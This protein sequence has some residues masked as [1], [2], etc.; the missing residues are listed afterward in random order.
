MIGYIK[1][2]MALIGELK[3]LPGIG[4]RGAERIAFSILDMDKS[5]VEALR[6]ALLDAKEKIEVCPIC[7]SI[8]DVVPCRICSDPLRDKK[9]LCIVEN[10][11]D[12]MALEKNGNYK[13]YY[14]VLEGSLSPAE[15]IGPEDLRIK[16]LLTRLNNEEDY[17]EI[18]LALNPSVEGEATALY[19]SKLLKPFQ[20][21]VTRIAHGLPIGGEL[22]FAD[23]MTLLYAFEDRKEL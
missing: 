17:E 11:K 22:E 21:K 4:P 12:V 6:Q 7:F 3:K 19:L 1:P 18:I 10:P 2:M 14:H 8:T 20:I 5:T 16:E 9:V 15:N 13:G 23:E